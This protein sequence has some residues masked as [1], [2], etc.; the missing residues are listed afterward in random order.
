MRARGRTRTTAPPAALAETSGQM[1]VELALLVPVVLAVALA[2]VNLMHFT[3]LCA[4]FDRVA[5]DAVLAHGVSPVGAP[6]GISGVDDVRDAVESAMGEGPFEVG[7]RVE[8]RTGP[9]GHATLDLAAGSVRYVCE[10][11]YRP[12][13]TSVEV[14]G[15]GYAAP[16]WLVHE[17]SVVVDRYRAAVVT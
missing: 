8:G 12:W 16:A 17:R 13:P 11:R 5:P 3:E 9:D 1:A 10:L 4:R 7:V 15:V 14:A 6:D 2:V